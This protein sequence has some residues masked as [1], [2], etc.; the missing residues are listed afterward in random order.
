MADSLIIRKYSVSGFQTIY[1]SLHG[2][3]VYMERGATNGL[4]CPGLG[5]V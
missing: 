1:P 2:Q 3:Y 4:K 5:L